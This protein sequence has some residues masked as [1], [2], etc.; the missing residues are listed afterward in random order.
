MFCLS[1]EDLQRLILD[2]AGGPASFN[3]ELTAQ[4]GR[5]ISCDPIYQFSAEAIAERI[6]AT[7]PVI[8]SGLEAM[9]DYFVWDEI[10]SPDALRKRRLAAMEGFLDDLPAGLASGRYRVA[11]LPNLPFSDRHFALGLCS[12][13]LFTY[14]DRLSLE[15]HVAAI[16]ELLRVAKEVRLFPL[17]ENYTGA[18]SPHLEP[19]LEQLQ[20]AGY[21]WRIEKADYEFQ[22]GG[23]RFLRIW[24]SC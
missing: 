19:V 3:T 16:V 21:T 22:K 14:S 13:L 24:Q 18:R 10:P 17:V 5:V 8:V 2:C 12:H 1:A 15:F 9:R 11:V 6:Q 23:D 7:A 20:A 4:G